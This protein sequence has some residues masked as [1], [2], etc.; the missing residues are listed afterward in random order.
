MLDVPWSKDKDSIASMFEFLQL[1][2]SP[3]NIIFTTL[4][5]GVFLYW[6]MFLVGAV[7]LDLFDIDADVDVNVDVD[8]DVGAP[9]VGSAHGGGHDAHLH[10]HG[11][12]GFVS[13]LR[14][15]NVGDVPLMILVSALVGTMWAVSILS[16]HYFNPQKSLLGAILWFVPNLLI[17]LLFTKIV[18][19]PFRYLFG[20]ANLGIQAPT[21]IVGKTCVITTSEV[22]PKFGQARIE[23][24]GAPITLN[25]R[26]SA[27]VTLHKGDEAVVT[28]HDTDTD[29]YFVYPFDLEVKS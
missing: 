18:T 11:S 2:F 14:F 20:K 10:G 21:R 27:D 1:C 6:T 4:L 13:V 22:T 23:Q 15:F 29:T 26:C 28:E 5:G 25:V 12:S 16:C 24:E 19:S 3:I 17:S 7:G 8:A 9:D